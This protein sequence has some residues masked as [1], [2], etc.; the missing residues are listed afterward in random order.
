V[1]EILHSYHIITLIHLDT[2]ALSEAMQLDHQ[3]PINSRSI[4][5]VRRNACENINM[6]DTD[7]TH[8]LPDVLKTHPFNTP[9]SADRN[10]PTPKKPFCTSRPKE[11]DAMS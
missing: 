1:E 3:A 10:H 8:K 2:Q 9:Y 6:I 5:R 7:A 11:K 4:E